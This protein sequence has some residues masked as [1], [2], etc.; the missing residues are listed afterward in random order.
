MSTTFKEVL[1][2]G[3]SYLQK[4]SISDAKIDAWQLME[5]VWEIN[6]SYY[7]VHLNDIIE[8]E[9]EEQ[10]MSLIY[11][12]GEY[13]PVQYITNQ[14]DFMG[15]TFYVNEQVLIPRQDT[16]SLVEAVLQVVKDGDRILDMCTGSG[17]II[18][19]LLLAKVGEPDV[20]ASDDD[21]Y[22]TTI[23]GVGVDISKTALA[24]AKKNANKLN[25]NVD[26]IKS[27]LFE[28]VDGIYDVIVSNPPYIHPEELESLM[29]EV[30]E[31]EP[32]LALDGKED[33]LY[34]YREI[35]KEASK[36][37]VAQGYLAFEIGYNQGEDVS[38]IMRSSGYTNVT[39]VKDLAGLDRVVIGR[40]S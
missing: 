17:C 19:S 24:V 2:K 34:Y 21:K 31:H 20:K 23:N 27:N 29:P 22:I 11:R 32:I 13:V 16:E 3:I 33:G 15:H 14:A 10:Y 25:I 12:R 6:R 9:K 35:V 5:F 8:P 30:R 28:K 39:I 1:D 26:F 36:F 38:G 37:L 4:N 40:S 18:L 7:F